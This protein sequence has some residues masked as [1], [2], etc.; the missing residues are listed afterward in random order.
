MSAGT[1]AEATGPTTHSLACRAHAIGNAVENIADWDAD[2]RATYA[3]ES[4]PIV[5]GDD[6]LADGTATCLCNATAETIDVMSP[7]ITKGRAALDDDAI[8]ALTDMPDPESDARY[9]AAEVAAEVAGWTAEQAAALAELEAVTAA[10]A[11][12][13]AAA[14]TATDDARAAR[15]ADNTPATREAFTAARTARYRAMRTHD[16]ARAVS[17]QAAWS[18][19]Q[20]TGV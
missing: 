17:H 3:S 11:I 19:P 1:T 18:A 15:R 20:R 8:A 10:A 13:F 2:T 16:D 14:C 9:L 7:W 5:T 12:V 6:Y 4:D